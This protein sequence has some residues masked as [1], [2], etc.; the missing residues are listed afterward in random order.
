[1]TYVKSPYISHP[2]VATRQGRTTSLVA[3]HALFLV[4]RATASGVI[5][6]YRSGGDGHV[7]AFLH[8]GDIFDLSKEGRYT[9]SAK[10]LTPVTAY[11]I[12]LLA[13][14][15][16]LPTDPDL[17]VDII[18]KLCEELRQ[19]Q[20][21]AFILARRRAVARL[22]MF[23]GLQE[24]L[25]ATRDKPIVEIRL[26]MDR[27]AIAEY[28]AMSLPHVSRAFRSLVADKIIFCRDLR[29]VKVLDRPALEKLADSGLARQS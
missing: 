4:Y 19:A 2:S 6:T 16:L 25:Q 22:A 21:H 3:F 24:H 10:A 8:R 15:R 9:N 17:N 11:R 18:I 12:P 23:L 27:S 1:M 29:H 28:L 20:R 7:T 26:G 5:A 13:L 14:Q